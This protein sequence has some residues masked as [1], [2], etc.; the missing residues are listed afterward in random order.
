MTETENKEIKKGITKQPGNKA[1]E[2]TRRKWRG[3]KKS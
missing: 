3:K 2:G 1:R